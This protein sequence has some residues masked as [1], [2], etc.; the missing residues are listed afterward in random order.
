MDIESQFCVLNDQAQVIARW[1][2]TTTTVF[3]REFERLR[4]VS[5]R[6]KLA[7]ILAMFS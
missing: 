1:L 2:P 5:W 7:L 3:R 4:R 6:S